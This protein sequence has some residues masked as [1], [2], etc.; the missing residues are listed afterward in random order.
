MPVIVKSITA[1]ATKWSAR[2]GVAVNDYLGGVANSQVDQAG[3]AAQA[4]PQWAAA[5]AAAATAHTFSAGLG[6]SGTAGWKAGV[7]SKGATRY[8]P[9]VA[10]ATPKYTARFGPFL[11]VIAGLDLGAR[12]P[13]GDP[14]NQQR[15]VVVQVALNKARM[16]H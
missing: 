8:A 14:R 2:A 4:E 15:S 5:V 3:R 13:R 12:F 9:G 11:N 7:A 16:G 1:A 6:R 10:A